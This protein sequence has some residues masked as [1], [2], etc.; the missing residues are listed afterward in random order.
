MTP[1]LARNGRTLKSTFLP[2]F[3]FPL[4]SPARADPCPQP[5]T[6]YTPLRAPNQKAGG[7][8]FA[9]LYCESTGFRAMWSKEGEPAPQVAPGRRSEEAVGVTRPARVSASAIPLDKADTV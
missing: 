1:I 6:P 7:L 2:I 3:S 9:V 4:S 8:A 5:E